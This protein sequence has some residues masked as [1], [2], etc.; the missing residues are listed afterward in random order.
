MDPR[1]HQAQ[2]DGFFHPRDSA[3]PADS[4]GRTECK[5]QGSIVTRKVQKADREKMRRD[6][7][8]EQFQEL[9]S[10]LGMAQ[11]SPEGIRQFI[12]P[13]FKCSSLSL[14]NGDLGDQVLCQ[15][16]AGGDPA[17]DHSASSGTLVIPEHHRL[18]SSSSITAAV[19]VGPQRQ[20]VV[21]CYTLYP[22]CHPLWPNLPRCSPSTTLASSA[23]S[24]NGWPS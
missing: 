19:F 6:R 23:I 11:L 17:R 18:T 20:H 9:G 4:S 16:C 21:V 13:H 3:C 22:D 15:Q 1:S 2:E 24:T 14:L 12:S 5:T 10:T 7:L 8:N